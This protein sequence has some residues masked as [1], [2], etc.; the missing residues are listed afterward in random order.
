MLNSN[1]S[2]PDVS[3]SSTEDN[4]NVTTTLTGSNIGH[5]PAGN[6]TL[7]LHGIGINENNISHSFTLYV[8]DSTTEYV[9]EQGTR[10]LT[11]TVLND[12]II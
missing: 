6:F 12:K 8:M 4:L 11:T 5:Y 7:T 9:I 10:I 2:K 3:C 1:S